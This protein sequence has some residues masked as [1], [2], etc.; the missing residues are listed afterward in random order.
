MTEIILVDP[1]IKQDFLVITPPVMTWA[2]VN[3][4]PDPDFV[5]VTTGNIA[6][7]PGPQGPAGPSGDGGGVVLTQSAP[8]ATWTFANPLNRVCGVSV[9]QGDEL[10]LADT[11]VTLD[12]I[13]ITWA[14]PTSGR[15]VIT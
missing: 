10:V 14:E 6:G 15:I 12:N 3:E 7:P 1:G 5:V 2:L 9:Y 11:E 4:D 8:A 13:T